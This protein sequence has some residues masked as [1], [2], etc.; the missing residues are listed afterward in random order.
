ML[1][2]MAV[3][4]DLPRRARVDQV[5]LEA[6]SVEC[7]IEGD[8]IHSSRLHRDHFHLQGLQPIGQPMEVVRKGGEV[9]DRLLGTLWIDRHPVLS[10][11]N[12]DT[13]TAGMNN[14]QAL[15]LSLARHHDWSRADFKA[16][17]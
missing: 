7:F 5:D 2:K 1:R 9:L 11:A 10:R 16:C 8:P 6:A 13:G 12:I 4:G 17:R 14:F 15:L 3:P